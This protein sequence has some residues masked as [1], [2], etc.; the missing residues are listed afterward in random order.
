[1][2]LADLFAS[3]L[4]GQAGEVAIEHERA[5]GGPASLR[6]GELHAQQPAGACARQARSGGGRSGWR[7]PLEPS[8][9]VDLL[10]A[11]VKLGLVLV[12]INILYREREIAHILA[13]AQLRIVVTTKEAFPAFEA[14]N[15][16]D[17]IEFTGKRLPSPAAMCP[18]GSTVTRRPRSSTHRA[19][20]ALEGRGAAHNNCLANTVNLLGCWR[21]TANDRYLAVLPLFHV[22]G[23]ANGLMTWLA[24]GCR[25]R[26]VERFDAE[27]AADWFLTFS[28]R[29]FRR[30]HHFHARLLEPPSSHS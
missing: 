4:V 14:A 13:D 25:M 10:L 12:P 24:S 11:C 29:S 15:P 1:M 23:L 7:L 30:A 8:R 18:C 6:F 20:R 3:S 5:D 22:H 27:R 17:A 26:L 9:I 28:R 19:R 16:V 2:Q 21:I